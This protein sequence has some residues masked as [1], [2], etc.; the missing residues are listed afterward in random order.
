MPFVITDEVSEPIRN[1]EPGLCLLKQCIQEVK[2][3][4]RIKLMPKQVK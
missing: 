2:C 3:G 4:H 1:T